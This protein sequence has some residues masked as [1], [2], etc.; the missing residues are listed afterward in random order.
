MG[1]SR[2]VDRVDA[3]DAFQLHAGLFLVQL[4]A[5]KIALAG[6]LSL[7]GLDGIGILDDALV[8]PLP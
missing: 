2:V 7:I 5:L 4:T 8:Q 1:I 3:H 6:S